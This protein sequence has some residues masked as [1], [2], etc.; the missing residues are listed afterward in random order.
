MSPVIL[1][2]LEQKVLVHRALYEEL[3][4]SLRVRHSGGS[5]SLQSLRLQSHAPLR[6]RATP[7][8]NNFERKLSTLPLRGVGAAGI[9]VVLPPMRGGGMTPYGRPGDSLEPARDE[10]R[11]SRII[12]RR[13][14]YLAPTG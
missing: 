4:D 14:G 11:R 12:E 7:S 3:H 1:E 6:E 5:S 10:F 13:S 2:N 9:A 8:S